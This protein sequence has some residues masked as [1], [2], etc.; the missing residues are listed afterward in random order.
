MIDHPQPPSSRSPS[1]Q[2]A[3]QNP[4]SQFGDAMGR[5]IRQLSSRTSRAFADLLPSTSSPL[6][7]PRSGAFNESKSGLRTAASTVPK[8]ERACQ[9]HTCMSRILPLP[10]P[11]A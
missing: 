8:G 10:W 1:K 9:M 4:F 11:G 5:G 6:G 2:D 7:Q 3:V